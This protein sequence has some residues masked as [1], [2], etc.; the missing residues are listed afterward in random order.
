[1]ASRHGPARGN[2]LTWAYDR[3]IKELGDLRAP[4]RYERPINIQEVETILCKWKSHLS[5]HYELGKDIIEVRHGL[6]RYAKCKLSQHLLAAGK[7]G[8]IW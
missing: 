8:G 6:L 1:M 3:L 4:P 5:G 2:V 7:R